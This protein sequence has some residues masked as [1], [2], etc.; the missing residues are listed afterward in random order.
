MTSGFNIAEKISKF[1]SEV[2]QN[3]VGIY[4]IDKI[5]S[6][7]AVNHYVVANLSKEEEKG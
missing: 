3:L 4:S 7:I 1:G 5:P 2:Y 6:E